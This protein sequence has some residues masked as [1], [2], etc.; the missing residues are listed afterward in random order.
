[1]GFP[2]CSAARLEIGRAEARGDKFGDPVPLHGRSIAAP[3]QDLDITAAEVGGFKDRL[4]AAAAWRAD[5]VAAAAYD[6]NARDLRQTEFMLRRGKRA[7]F[8]TNAEAVAGV[9]H[10][11]A[12]HDLTIGRFYRATD[13]EVRIGRIC[14]RGRGAGELKQLFICHGLVLKRLH[15]ACASQSD[16]REYLS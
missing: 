12:C 11:C 7:L 8:G 4:A 15:G 10:V 5:H 2:D 16:S 13:I 9:F 3:A 6:G 14:L 1:M